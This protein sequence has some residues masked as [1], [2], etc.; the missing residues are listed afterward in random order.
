MSKGIVTR[1]FIG[2]GL[3]MIA[4]AIAAILAVSI[5]IANDVFVMNGSDLVG[6]RWSPIAWLSLGLGIAGFLAIMGGLIAG[7]VSWIGA[8]LN[9]WQ[10]ESKAWFIGLLL[11]GIFNLGFFAM[12]AYL[13]A[14]PDG[15]SAAAPSG[16]QAPVPA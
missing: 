1:L 15:K 10:L 13:I 14:G 2:A 11:L 8:L 4:G 7:L 3:A 9:T 6:L 12:V 16:A 5:A